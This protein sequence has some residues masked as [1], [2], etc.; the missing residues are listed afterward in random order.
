LIACFIEGLTD[1]R[2]NQAMHTTPGAKQ[3]KFGPFNLARLLNRKHAR[4]A[5]V[6]G[7]G[8][9]GVCVLLFFL[10]SLSRADAI[11]SEVGGLPLILAL[12]ASA[13]VLILLVRNQLLHDRLQRQLRATR[14]QEKK[15]KL[16]TDNMTDVV[17]RV[18]RDQR[19]TYISPSVKKMLGYEPEELLGKPGTVMLEPDSA[20]FAQHL[21]EQLVQGAKRGEYQGWAD[22]TA[23]VQQRHKNGESLWGEAVVR[24]F[25]TPDGEYDGAQGTTRDIGDRKQAEEAIRQLAFNDPLTHLPNRRLLSDRLNQAL[26]NCAR[27]RETCAIFFLDLDNFK[28]INDNY[29]HDE[30][31]ALL[32]EVA[33]RLRH[34]LRESDTIAR[35]GGDEFVIIS[36]FLGE[37]FGHAQSSAERIGQKI[38][39]LFNEPFNV[40]GKPYQVHTSVGV[41]LC[42]GNHGTSN[43]VLRQAD[44]AMYKAKVEGHNRVFISSQH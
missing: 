32:R 36:Q 8:I 13:L 25:F 41:A 38:I 39:E 3:P 12:A 9:I 7:L 4:H 21:S 42:D 30:G 11:A 5:R 29:G 17:W 18:D 16:L 14:E 31:D 2:G 37:E 1:E 10:P 24:V 20:E 6:R 19:I 34:H 40:S 27:H 35:F 23:E 26:I 44:L 28:D 33:H 43:E 15:L 22:T